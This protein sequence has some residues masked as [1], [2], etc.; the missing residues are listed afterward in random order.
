[1]PIGEVLDNCEIIALPSSMPL[2]DLP[3]TTN[4]PTAILFLDEK[5]IADDEPLEVIK[6]KWPNV[7]ILT[8][9]PIE[10]DGYDLISIDDISFSA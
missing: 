2:A 9:I 1:M 8:T 6:R 7:P 4:S 3:I 5:S 10:G